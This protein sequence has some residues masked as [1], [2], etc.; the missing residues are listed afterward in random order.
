MKYKNR[1]TWDV[2]VPIGVKHYANVVAD[3]VPLSQSENDVSEVASRK[4]VDNQE[5]V[6]GQCW[7]GTPLKYVRKVVK[8]ESNGGEQEDLLL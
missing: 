1:H 4:L 5:F 3:L 8:F 2:A 6:I 7:S